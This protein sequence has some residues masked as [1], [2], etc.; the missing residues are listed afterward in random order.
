MGAAEQLKSTNEKYI[1]GIVS[2][3]ESQ[4][5]A[6]DYWN[7]KAITLEV[8]DGL[9]KI[10]FELEVIKGNEQT[11]LLSVYA[12]DDEDTALEDLADSVKYGLQNI[13]DPFYSNTQSQAYNQALEIRKDQSE[14]NFL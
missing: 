12:M 4:I 14:Y 9:N 13:Y 7:Q 8:R 5:D 10:T 3:F 1:R 6:L 11:E 2:K